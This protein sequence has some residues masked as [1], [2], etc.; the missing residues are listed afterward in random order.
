MG[1]GEAIEKLDG[2]DIFSKNGQLGTS[3]GGILCTAGMVGLKVN[4][5]ITTS[6]WIYV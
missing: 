3:S 2:K 6:G 5:T 1:L 4:F